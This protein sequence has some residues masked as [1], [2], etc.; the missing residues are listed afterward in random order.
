MTGVMPSGKEQCKTKRYNGVVSPAQ[1][2]LVYVPCWP[3]PGQDPVDAITHD[4]G[5][6]GGLGNAAAASLQNVDTRSAIDRLH[7]GVSSAQASKPFFSTVGGGYHNGYHAVPR[8][9]GLHFHQW[10][11]QVQQQQQHLPPPVLEQ[12][13]VQ[14]HP[15]GPE[16]VPSGITSPS[17]R[18]ASGG[19]GG[20]GK[21]L[22]VVD[23]S[24][25][26]GSVKALLDSLGVPHLLPNFL[27]HDFDVKAV[28]LMMD[29]DYETLKVTLKSTCWLKGWG[30]DRPVR[31]LYIPSGL[32]RSLVLP[33]F[34]YMHP[35]TFQSFT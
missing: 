1:D 19:G 35:F 13:P 6:L 8:Q 27:E 3:P 33:C 10:Q 29:K 32:L 24:L 17:G 25:P 15:L 20:G 14:Q 18:D 26:F 12:I 30:G 23:E 34:K 22:R 5:D 28:G 21:D 7:Q 9:E 31:V 2:A 11:Q 4:F 16:I